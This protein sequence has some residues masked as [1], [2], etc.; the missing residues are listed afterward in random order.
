MLETYPDDW[1]PDGIRSRF[2]DDVNGMRMHVL[3]AGNAAHPA[4][5]GRGEV[6]PK[7]GGRVQFAEAARSLKPGDDPALLRARRRRR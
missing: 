1:L 5:Y 4:A 6:S 2:V 3:E 7:R